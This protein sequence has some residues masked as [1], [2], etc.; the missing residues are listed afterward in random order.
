MAAH[1]ATTRRHV[2]GEHH[3][4]R[5]DHATGHSE[6]EC[7]FAVVR[8]GLVTYLELQDDIEVVRRR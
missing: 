6:A 3:P 4:R 5:G 1:V 7:A 8:R 2:G